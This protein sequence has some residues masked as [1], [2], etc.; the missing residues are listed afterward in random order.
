VAVALLLVVWG[1]VLLLR[2]GEAHFTR[3]ALLTFAIGA[4]IGLFTFLAPTWPLLAQGPQAV[5]GFVPPAF[6]WLI[7]IL[8]WLAMAAGLAQVLRRRAPP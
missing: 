3:A 2:A 6:H 4:L 8:G 5:R 7:F 1:A